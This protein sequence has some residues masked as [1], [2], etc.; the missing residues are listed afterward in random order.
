M[1]GRGAS[2]PRRGP[3]RAAR[4][5]EARECLGRDRQQ[6]LPVLVIDKDVFTPVITEG[7]VID[8][9]GEFDTQ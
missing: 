2:E 6:T 4:D 9:A 8:G 1:S 5:L 7:D 3:V